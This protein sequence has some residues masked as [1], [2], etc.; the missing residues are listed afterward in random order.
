MEIEKNVFQEYC[1]YFNLSSNVTIL[2]RLEVK[3]NNMITVF[4]SL[5]RRISQTMVLKLFWFI[6]LIET[7]FLQLYLKNLFLLWNIFMINTQFKKL[8]RLTIAYQMF[9]FLCN[10]WYYL[11]V[12]QNSITILY[13]CK[14]IENDFLK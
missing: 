2:R 10:S 12:V 8:I 5:W 11:I 4:L 6:F 14:I 3:T 7:N 13:T 9:T 1:F